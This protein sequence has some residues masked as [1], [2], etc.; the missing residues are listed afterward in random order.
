MLE[1]ER[2]A[3]LVSGASTCALSERGRTVRVERVGRISN[4]FGAREGERY[5][6]KVPGLSLPSSQKNLI[7][8]LNCTPRDRKQVWRKRL[9]VAL[10]LGRLERL[11][12]FAAADAVRNAH[13]C[14][15]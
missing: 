5:R 12:R 1:H 4:N 6:T 13:V 9:L 14:A 8:L 11:E 2:L 15:G 3:C 10:A 7:A